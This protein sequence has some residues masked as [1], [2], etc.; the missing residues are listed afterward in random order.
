VPHLA[1]LAH[2]YR[3]SATI[4]DPV[5]AI[6]YSIRAG[7]AALAI[8]AYEETAS[9]WQ[10]ALGLMECYDVNAA[11]RGDLLRQLGVMTFNTSDYLEGIKYLEASLTVCTQLNDDRMTG[12]ACA[13]LGYARGGKG[14]GLHVNIPEALMYLEKAEALLGNGEP[15]ELA[16]VYHGITGSAFATQETARALNAARRGMELAEQL[17]DRPLRNLIAACCALHL[18]VIGKHSE[19]AT[20]L[21]RAQQASLGIHEPEQSRIILWSV[22]LYY[23][24]LRDPLEARSMFLLDLQ[25][26]GLSQHQRA[27]DSQYLAIT[28]MFI[29]NLGEAQK[30]ADSYG[31]NAQFRSQ[32]AFYLGDFEAAK[33]MQLEHLEYSRKVHDKWNECNALCHL[34]NLLRAMADYEG[35]EAIL[36]QTLKAYRPEHAYW[37]MRTRPQAALLAV[38]VGQYEKAAEH[39]EVCL[40]ILELGENWRG[41]AGTVERAEAAIQAGLDRLEDAEKFFQRAIANFKQ[42]A[43]PFEVAETFHVWGQALLNAGDRAGAVEKFDEAIDLYHRHGAGQIWMDRI[44]TD[45]GRATISGAWRSDPTSTTYLTAEKSC[46]L[47]YEGDYW[48]ISFGDK[49]V[50]L[51]N[52]KGLHYLAY[53]VRHPGVEV[54]AT[55]LAAL[56]VYSA[57]GP[58]EPTNG[59]DFGGIRRD[60][61][62]AGP[63]LD[64]RAKGAYARRIK[65]LGAELAEAERFN[66]IGRAER[67]RSELEAL[68]AQLKAATGLSR[69]DR[70]TASHTDRARSTVSKRIRFAIRKIE[71]SSPALGDHLSKAIRTGYDCIYQPTETIGWHF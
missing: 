49:T 50:R 26:P 11:R 10:A 38:D 43:L 71:K 59:G 70:R 37:E 63:Q 64:A 55:F 18:M 42:Y 30:L 19:A 5:K 33:Q 31:I 25:R 8:F 52:T 28:E 27:F 46:S 12:L 40:R 61:G 17:N 47:C 16:R 14:F 21:D 3:E 9:H 13:E 58:T 32:L 68:E 34:T 57:C 62:D 51:R 22:G 36:V 29:G 2:H 6:D 1:E 4:G 69:I 39:L 24:L 66:D 56:N 41:L 23:M 54:P 20:L 35:A 67:A 60:L 65:D 7:K 53:L 48:L 45:R 15:H 44:A